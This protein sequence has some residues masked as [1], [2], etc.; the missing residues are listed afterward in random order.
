MA[1]HDNNIE[2]EENDVLEFG[3]VIELIDED[4]KEV[5]FTYEASLEVDG[6]EYVV[7]LPEEQSGENEDSEEVV[8]LR[9]EKGE[10]GEDGL[11]SIEDE[12]EEEKVFQE[13]LKTYESE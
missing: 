11:E 5:K 7:L 10:N 4:G 3:E 2:E 13:F 1:D 12:E 8:I 9:V 6:K